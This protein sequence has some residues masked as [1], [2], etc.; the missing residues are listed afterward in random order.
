[1][2][3]VDPKNP[4]DGCP[5]ISDAK[6]SKP[7]IKKDRPFLIVGK[8]PSMDTLQ[9]GRIIPPM[10]TATLVANLTEV[11]FKGSQFNWCN[12]V[13][14]NYEEDKY[15][16]SERKEIEARCRYHLLDVIEKCDPEV[17][18]PLGKEAA[19]QVYGKA[20]KITK[21][22]G[23]LN[24]LEE[25]DCYTMAI[26]D[27]VLANQY[28]ANMPLLASDCEAL[29]RMWDYEYDMVAVEQDTAGKYELVDDLQFLIDED[30][31]ELSVD[32]ETQ[33]T[34]PHDE[35]GELLTIQFCPEPGRAY[36]LS[37]DHP[38]RPM[39][40]R[41]RKKIRQQLREL[42]C[43]PGRSLVGQNM[44][45]DAS[46]LLRRM[47]IH[48][49]MDHDTL[50]LAVLVDENLQNKDL[51]TLVKIYVREMAGYADQ[52]NAEI[53]KSNM[54]DVPLTRLLD[55]GCGDADAALRLKR[56]LVKKVYADQKLWR[57]YRYVSM[58][59]LNAFLSFEPDG[60]LI[61][62][63]AFEEFEEVLTAQV[64]EEYESLIG[65]VHNTILQKYIDPKKTQRGLSFG[66]A[67]FLR[68]ILFTHKKGFRLHPKVW[69]K[70]T[71]KLEPKYR[72]AS[73]STK[74]HLPY[75]ADECPFAVEVSEHIKNQRIL[76]TNVRR[77]RENY[78][79]NGRV[80]PVYSLMQAVTG[81]TSSRDPNGQNFPKRGEAAKAYRKI[82]VPPRGFVQ[83]EADLSQAELRIAAD[84]AND[85]VM[86]DIFNNDGDIH[87]ST[88]C[89]VMRCT[90]DQFYAL[91]P[92]QQKSSRFK[93]KAVNFGFLYGM[94][95]K[96]FIGYAKTQ[97]GVDFTDEQAEDIRRRFF[98]TYSSLEA[99]HWQMKDF[100]QTNGYVRSYDGR[101]RHLPSVY[102]DTEWIQ[103]EALR[104]AINS[105]VQEFASSLG[106]MSLS[107]ITTQ[108]DPRCL[109]VKGFVHDSIAAWVPVEYA[110]WGAKTLKYYM[111]SNP[112]EE[113]FGR[114]MK[115]RIKADVGFGMN[116][117]DLHEMKTLDLDQDYDFGL[118]A[119]D[120][121]FELPRQR[122][123]EDDGMIWIPEHLR[124]P[125][126]IHLWN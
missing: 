61:D 83:L 82:F 57:S 118:H 70:T 25:F 2:I 39:P 112:I 35:A 1:M 109:Q 29:Y 3:E 122:V 115:V 54:R 111:E 36:M 60:M 38:D 110:E 91:S 50:M 71:T 94:W 89:I 84:M 17:I 100:A 116:S 69:T 80:Y 9:G 42:L 46:W 33:G 65:Q 97:Y 87:T 67:E 37:W 77:F 44:K 51:D 102:S 108:I 81:R 86:L 13:R 16:A 124:A 113:W 99:W 93:A 90:E 119:D 22:R 103:K 19:K 32:V 63:P 74:T 101:V 75:F 45:F 15:P 11:G 56:V 49:R 68:D 96:S 123:P 7:I 66:R 24:E 30:P 48:I 105:P 10:A 95:W 21:V 40:K 12:A 78:I 18:V 55:Y 64:K 120:M 4:C 6:K 20:V 52:F 27:P 43:K 79:Y 125:E 8:A 47:G 106:V 114:K 28:P 88:A 34:R 23:V 53:D 85:R 98:E 31:E 117:S 126:E 58:P 76:G 121:D 5:I 41:K 14:C 26:T 62:E 72:V 107:R 104:Q 73:V 92:D 59:G